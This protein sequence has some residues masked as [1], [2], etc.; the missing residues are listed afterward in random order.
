MM[1]TFPSPSLACR[2]VGF[3][4]VRLQGRFIGRG[5]PTRHPEQCCA[6]C[7]RP[8]CPPLASPFSSYCAEGRCA[9][10]HHRSSGL[11]RFTP[12]TLAPTRLCSPGHQRLSGPIRPTRHLATVSLPSRLYVASLLC[13]STPRPRP[14]TSGSRLSKNQ[15]FLTCHPL[16][17]RGVRNRVLPVSRSQHGLCLHGQRLGSPK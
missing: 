10:E 15:S 11:H 7:V 1:P 4:S 14:M 8:S 5:L 16:R 2:T 3:P 6:V 9:L 12:G 17:P 13:R